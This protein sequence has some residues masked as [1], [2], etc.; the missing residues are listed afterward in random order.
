MAL[1]AKTSIYFATTASYA[2]SA[3]AGIHLS[4]MPELCSCSYLPANGLL[5]SGVADRLKPH[6]EAGCTVA[7]AA[8]ILGVSH[9]ILGN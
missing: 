4:L 5:V 1:K 9:Y 2:I 8:Q 3:K 7:L 6:D